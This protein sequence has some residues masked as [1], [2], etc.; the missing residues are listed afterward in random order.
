MR[1]GRHLLEHARTATPRRF[2]LHIATLFLLAAVSASCGDLQRQG[3]SASYLLVGSLQASSGADPTTFTGNL[4]SDVITV[5]D[6]TPTV[7]NDLGQIVATVVLKDPGTA[8]SPT[9]PTTAN[10]ITI[11]RYHVQYIRTDGRNT[12]GVDVPYAFDG[13]MTLTVGASESTGT[14]TIVRHIA[15]SEAPL[16]ALAVNGVVLSTIAEVTFYG[17]DQ[18]GREVSA[19][20]HISIDFANFGDKI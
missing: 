16:K 6:G 8:T 2:R 13:G 18:S 5:V 4:G 10:S 14:F 19:V 12:Q 17:H 9:T 15:K 3:Q 7:F 20:A 11:D 1:T